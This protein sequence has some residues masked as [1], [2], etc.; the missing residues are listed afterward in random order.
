M[1][2]PQLPSRTTCS[3]L[4]IACSDFR[5]Q[6]VEREFF[7]RAGLRD[8]YDLIA[9]PGSIRSLV[10]PRNEAAR[11]SMEEEISILHRIHAFERVVMINHASCRAYDDIATTANELDLHADHLEQAA[12][13]IRELLGGVK[14]ETFIAIPDGNAFKLNATA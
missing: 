7:E 9:R 3:A 4:V 13:R 1:T 6:S 8:D 5:V 14:P 10:A 2:A 11:T 12:T